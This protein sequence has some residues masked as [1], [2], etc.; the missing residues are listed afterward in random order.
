M[1]PIWRY[2]AQCV[3]LANDLHSNDNGTYWSRSD[4]LESRR[5]TFEMLHKAVEEQREQAADA[6]SIC[7][8]R[9]SDA[10]ADA[11]ALA[12]LE[13]LRHMELVWFALLV[14]IRQAEARKWAALACETMS[15]PTATDT[16]LRGRF[17]EV[18]HRWQVAI[19]AD[20]ERQHRAGDW[21][22]HG[23]RFSQPPAS[24]RQWAAFK[25]HVMQH[26]IDTFFPSDVHAVVALDKLNQAIDREDWPDV[27]DRIDDL[28]HAIHR[29]AEQQR[30]ATDTCEA[31]P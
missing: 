11:H 26:R 18:V 10:D 13:H 20:R 24:L 19:D 21:Y 3:D 9:T 8:Q 25:R 7:W 29:A 28:D 2:R 23:W 16:E 22:R 14:A 31:Q 12:E 6:W 4:Y 1:M 17:A 27:A 5:R 15:W 30:Q